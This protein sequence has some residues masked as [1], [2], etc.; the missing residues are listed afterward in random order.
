MSEEEQQQQQ[1]E[2]HQKKEAPEQSVKR[3]RGRG[4]GSG[5]KHDE[6]FETIEQKGGH[7]DDPARSV[8]GWV[9]IVTGLGEE[10]RDEDLLDHF[11]EYGE[12]KSIHLNLDR[13][14]GD[15]KGYA[16]IE[17][18][19]KSCAEE[20]ISELDGTNF[21]G[22]PIY[23]DWAFKVGPKTTPGQTVIRR[24]RDRSSSPPRRRK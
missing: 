11:N 6:I 16:F 12:T 24:K 7:E 10:V 17:Y 14:T 2:Q 13:C 4:A 23:V 20:A 21:M 8:E 19:E 1:Q 22:S 5:W 9:I 15:P 18:Q 3:V